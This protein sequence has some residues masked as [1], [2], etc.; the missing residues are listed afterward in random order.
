VKGA[1]KYAR[2]NNLK[3][4]CVDSFGDDYDWCDKIIRQD[5]LT[6]FE[7]C[8]FFRDAKV[9][10]TCTYHGLMFGLIFN[11]KIVFHPTQFILDKANSLIEQ[12]ELRDVLVEYEEFE[13]KV[14]WNW[15]F[16]V[17][18]KRID[19]LREESTTFLLE[20]IR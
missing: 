6:P 10:M 9:V 2:E 15:N 4:I 20:S 8:A 7:W 16:D 13:Q 14:E 18:N 17:I 3:I 1:K 5:D 11:K 12:L 19:K